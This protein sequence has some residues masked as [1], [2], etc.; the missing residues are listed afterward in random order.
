MLHRHPRHRELAVQRIHIYAH[1]AI[2]V[3]V[4]ATAGQLNLQVLALLE[5]EQIAETALLG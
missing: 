3:G 1:Q 2:G 5:I 4:R